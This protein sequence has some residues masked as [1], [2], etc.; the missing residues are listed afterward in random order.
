M[1]PKFWSLCTAAI[2]SLVFVFGTLA[3]ASPVA[4]APRGVNQVEISG[5]VNI[6]TAPEAK[7]RMLPGIGQKKARAIIAHRTQKPFMQITDLM[8]IK[9][10]N[11][12][13]FNR[14]K[15]FI[16]T[17]GDTSILRRRIP[18]EKTN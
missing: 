1:K 16:S 15:P 7:L 8:Q 10:F 9:G 14:I 11:Q 13:L 6:N 12:K 5:M 3:G 4:A 2:L 17:A 18:N